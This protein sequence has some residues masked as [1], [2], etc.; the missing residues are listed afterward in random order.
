M[1]KC[2]YGKK[3]VRNVVMNKQTATEVN[4]LMAEF[5]LRLDTSVRLVQ[6]TCPPEI[7]D[8]YRDAVG[9]LLGAMLIEIMNPIYQHYPELMP[10]QLHL[11]D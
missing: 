8:E 10:D 9:R 3:W 4:S 5:S 1:C 7:F 2:L 11:R 6:D